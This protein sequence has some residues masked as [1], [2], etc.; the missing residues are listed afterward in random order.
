MLHEEGIAKLQRLIDEG[1]NEIQNQTLFGSDITTNR[2]LEECE[3][4]MFSKRKKMDQI[5]D[6]IHFLRKV[7]FSFF[8]FF[9]CFF[10]GGACLLVHR[11]PLHPRF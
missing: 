8:L 5:R 10:N 4:K 11:H 7:R 9:K 2:M 3:M 6:Q 1:T